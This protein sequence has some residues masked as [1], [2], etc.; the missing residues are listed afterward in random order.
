[1]GR[2][3]TTR[4]GQ[5]FRKGTPDPFIVKQ[6]GYVRE[7]EC[8]SGRKTPQGAVTHPA[9]DRGRKGKSLSREG[10]KRGAVLLMSGGE[11]TLLFL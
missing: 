3:V 11:I 4:A 6:R 10:G 9:I 8:S 5:E 2:P 1:M 7:G